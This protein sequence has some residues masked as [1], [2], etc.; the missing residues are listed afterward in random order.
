[1]VRRR[2]AKGIDSLRQG[3][4]P[5]ERGVPFFAYPG[6]STKSHQAIYISVHSSIL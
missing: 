3:E 1:V 4:R 5:L 2:E 6:A